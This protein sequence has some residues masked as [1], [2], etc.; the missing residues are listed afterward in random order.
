MKTHIGPD[1]R[2][3]ELD[4]SKLQNQVDKLQAEPAEPSDRYV[5][6]FHDDAGGWG[7]CG[8]A[9]NALVEPGRGYFTRPV[10]HGEDHSQLLDSLRPT[11]I[12]VMLD[13]SFD[14]TVCDAIANRVQELTVIDNHKS[15]KK[16]LEG[17]PY[18]I[19]KE[20]MSNVLA[21]YMHYFGK[22]LGNRDV[23]TEAFEYIPIPVRLLDQYDMWAVNDSRVAWHIVRGFHLMCVG[24]FGRYDYWREIMAQE[25]LPSEVFLAINKKNEEFAFTVND[26]IES[27]NFTETEF[28]GDKFGTHQ[29]IVY[30]C[31]DPSYV[32][33]LA[34]EMR[35][36]RPHHDVIAAYFVRE[37]GK[38]EVSLR[39]N[40]NYSVLGIA[41]F[42]KGGGGDKAA[43]FT[44][45]V[46][47][48]VDLHQHVIHAVNLGIQGSAMT[49]TNQQNG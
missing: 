23:Q 32:S 19:C 25:E 35:A 9:L 31:S 41:T 43:G 46:L 4:L 33:L 14:R 26:L 34:E 48:N 29:V 2:E 13:F 42:N 1:N 5:I 37:D 22:L 47:P 17:A 20:G 3:Q 36:R 45:E 30:P 28:S 10:K 12:V 6:I 40:K 8:L 18:Y 24:L 7:C 39:G 11:D 49:N 16:K 27:A 15:A 44:M 21:T 38:L